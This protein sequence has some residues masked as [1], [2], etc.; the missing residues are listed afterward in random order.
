MQSHQ[1]ISSL[2]ALAQ[3]HRLAAFRLLVEAGA[4]G[5]PAGMLADKLGVPP[6][7]MSFHL[8]QLSHAGLV[9]QRR[10]SRSIIYSADYAAMNALM[11]YL[12]ENCCGGDDCAAVCAPA[13]RKE[14][15]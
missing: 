14:P 6:S 13:D 15:A 10:E 8:A 7:S 2:A 12:T 5:I 9:T 1:V 11:G 4:E 3:E